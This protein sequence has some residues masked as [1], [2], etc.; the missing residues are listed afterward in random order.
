[1]YSSG[2]T[3][4]KLR[5]SREWVSE[6]IDTFG[7]DVRFSEET[8]DWVTVTACVNEMAMKQFVKSYAPDVMV[9]EP[10][11]L[12]EEIKEEAEMTR[13]AYQK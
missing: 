1:M 11:R 5:V 10:E 6:V 2:N 13:K 12:R 8:E 7:M 9:L 3:P 4:V